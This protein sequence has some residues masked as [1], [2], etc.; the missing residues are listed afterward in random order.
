MKSLI[1]AVLVTFV[2]TVGIARSTAQDYKLTTVEKDPLNVQMY[3]LD[4]GL[5]VYISV[6]KDQPRIQ[7]CIAVN[8]GSKNDPADATGLAHYLEHMVFKGN[9]QF[10]TINWK[11]E[12]IELKKISNLYEDHRNESDPEKKRA[13]YHRID[14][15]SGVAAK[16]AVANEYDKMISSLGATGTNAFTSL[17]QTVYINDIPAVELEKF[18][19]LESMRF[20]ELTLRLFHTELEAVYEE[21][22]R[23]QDNDFSVSFEKLNQLVYQKHPYGTQTT[24]GTGEHLK[25]P[26]MEKIHAYFDKYYVPNNMAICLAGDLDPGETIKL[27]DQYFGKMEKRDLPKKVMPKEDPIAAHRDDEVLGPMGEWLMMA[28]RFDGYHS[29]DPIMID[30]I[31]SILSNGQAGLIDLDIMQKQKMLRAQASASIN[32][33]Y[34][35]MML[36]GMPKQGQSLKEVR[37]LFLMELDKLKNG[38]FDDEL[39][40]TIIRNQRVDEL[41]GFKGNWSRAMVMVNA[42]IMGANWADF[43]TYFDRMSKITKADVMKFAKENF[44]DNYCAL[45]KRYGE[46]PNVYKVDKPE[47]TPIDINR[48]QTSVFFDKFKNKKSSRLTPDF[49]DYKSAL[50]QIEI[51]K[52]V[53]LCYIKNKDDKLFTL[54]LSLDEKTKYDNKLDLALQYLPYLSTSK[55]TAAEL[56]KEFYRLAI[57]FNAYQSNDGTRVYISGLQ[58]SFEESVR[59][60][61]HIMH[62]V[63]PDEEALRQLISDELKSRSDSKKNKGAILRR[64]AARA[65]YGELNPS[66]HLLSEQELKKIHPQELVD[67]IQGLLDYEHDLFYYGPEEIDAVLASL[68]KDHI[69]PKEVKEYDFDI[70]FPELDITENSVYF[71]D[72]DMVQTEIMFV[73][74]GGKFNPEL[75]AATRLFNQYFGSGLSSIVFQ[76]IREA[77]ALAYSS[78][79]GYGTP[80]KKDRS[81]YVTAYLGTQTNKLSQ[82]VDALLE[83]MNDMPEAQM[84][85]DQSKESALKRIESERIIKSSIYWNYLSAKKRGLDRDIRE[86]IYNNLK[87][88]TFADLK[89]FFVEHIKGR[90]FAY[91]LIGKKSEIDFEAIGKLGAVTELTL[92]EVFAY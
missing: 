78:Y 38:D 72:Y 61:E 45:Y 40:P 60:F 25:N 57:D 88:M 70:D 13:I 90:K 39:I 6:N 18:L 32:H 19:M 36:I 14:S 11:A 76:E 7:T 50:K 63:E 66:T 34:S 8:T 33:D 44:K 51:K 12:K 56:Q 17:E 59:L 62:N 35:E 28:Y 42:F 37:D 54:F 67:I 48:E 27:I 24:I 5:K 47:I 83:L 71:V 53:N 74:K 64:I 2:F 55:Y 10:A 41:K 16:Y 30:L 91:C 23:G 65:K 87:K 85:F 29:K 15:I 21:F 3:T 79:V 9:S 89:A 73:S 20:S 69:L 84:Q 31:G 92:D 58:E 1:S 80:S 43:V 22:N 26:S 46:N 52:G 86:D 49:V 81:H 68:K 77:K 75:M 82:A 4:N